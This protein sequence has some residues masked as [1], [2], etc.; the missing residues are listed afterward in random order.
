M[1]RWGWW[2]TPRRP[3]RTARPWF[4]TR[5]PTIS[6]STWKLADGDIDG[7]FAQAEVVIK[8]RLVNQ[9]LIPNAME[10]RAVVGRFDK[11]TGEITLWDT[12][13]N[14]HVDP[15]AALPGDGPARA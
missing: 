8:Q 10:P 2:S 1:S 14:P 7:A 15:P 12:D 4:T 6:R 9:R 5:C 3:L 11:A 13:Q